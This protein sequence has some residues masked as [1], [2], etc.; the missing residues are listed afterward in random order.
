VRVCIS[1]GEAL[2]AEILERWK[3]GFGVG[4]MDGIG[5]TEILPIF[6]STHLNDMR[7]GFTGKLVPGY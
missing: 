7:S 5:S 1:A 2:P 4:I 6:I 3:A